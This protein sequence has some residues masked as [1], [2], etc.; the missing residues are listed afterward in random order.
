MEIG[1]KVIGSVQFLDRKGRP[2]KVDGVPEWSVSDE[3]VVSMV[4]ADDGMSAEFEALAEGAVVV[5]VGADADLGDDVKQIIGVGSLAV[6][7][8]E[9]VGVEISFGEPQDP[10]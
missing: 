1:Q 10:A 8:A 7:P 4:V 3:A 6:L 9:A 2:A 5:Q